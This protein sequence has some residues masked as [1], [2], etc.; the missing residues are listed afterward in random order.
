MSTSKMQTAGSGTPIQV[1]KSDDRKR[2]ISIRALSENTAAPVVPDPPVDPE[3]MD[4][5]ALGATDAKPA[6]GDSLS[7][8][9]HD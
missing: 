9:Q 8:D 7:H 6:S 3:G 2:F 1:E 5:L 4:A